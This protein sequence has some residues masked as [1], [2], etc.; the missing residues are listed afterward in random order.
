MERRQLLRFAATAACW[1][2]VLA[3]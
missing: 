1:G 2:G 3:T